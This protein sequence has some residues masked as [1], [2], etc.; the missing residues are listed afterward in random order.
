MTAD[1]ITPASGRMTPPFTRET[2]RAKVKAA[3]YLST[4]VFGIIARAA[5]ASLGRPK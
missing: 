4:N 2:A 3:G 5:R 1:N